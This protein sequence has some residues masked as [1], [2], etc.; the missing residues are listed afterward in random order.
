[1]SPR[2]AISLSDHTQEAIAT[3]IHAIQIRAYAQEALLLGLTDFPPLKQRVGNVLT[4]NSDFLVAEWGGQLVGAIEVESVS[5][6]PESSL[7]SV[8]VDPPFQRR[9]VAEQML[10][11]VLHRYAHRTITV[12]TAILNTPAL[13]LY[14]KFGFIECKRWLE[15][16]Q[17][18]AMV[19]LKREVQKQSGLVLPRSAL[20]N[21]VQDP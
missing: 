20:G 10:K 1:M 16:P 6:K 21:V 4:S 12:Q 3:A 8:V 17:M 2:L 15:V 14:S 13:K 9:G 19:K 7:S 18:L 5:G 11:D